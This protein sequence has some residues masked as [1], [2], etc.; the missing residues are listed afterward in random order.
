[1]NIVGT[2]FVLAEE[3]LRK[4]NTLPVIVSLLFPQLRIM[5]RIDRIEPYGDEGKYRLIFA[6][7]AKELPHPIPFADAPQGSMQGPRYARLNDLLVAK[8][9]TDIF[10][11]ERR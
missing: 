5:W 9:V 8:K 10:N 7:A 4:L 6:E 3:Y 1:M 11:D 2:P